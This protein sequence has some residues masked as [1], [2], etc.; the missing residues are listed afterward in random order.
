SALAGCVG[1][2]GSTRIGRHCLLGWAVGVVGHLDI[3]D[4]V[5][6]NG[7]S[8]VSSSI[9]EPGVYGSGIP[10]QE[11]RRWRRNLVRLHALD[12]TTRRLLATTRTK[13]EPDHD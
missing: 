4:R 7:F 5:V 8:M 10:A 2:A 1:V 9:T 12:D 11:H 3:C 13:D 6:I